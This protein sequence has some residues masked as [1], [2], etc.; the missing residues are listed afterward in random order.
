M[1]PCLRDFERFYETP[2]GHCVR[3]IVRLRCQAVFESWRGSPGPVLFCGYALPYADL[4]AG[5][6]IILMHQAQ[7]ACA[8]PDIRHNRVVLGNT[9]T[10]PLRAHQFQKAVLIH[11]LEFDHETTFGDQLWEVLA[12]E[13]EVLMI[14]PN[15]RSALVQWGHTPWGWGTSSPFSEF[16][17]LLTSVGFELEEYKNFFFVPPAH[18]PVVLS[19]ADFCEKWGPYLLGPF[20]GLWL[21]RARKRVC[22]PVTPGTHSFVWRPQTFQT[23]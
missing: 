14:V 22:A 23:I 7:G 10:M 17:N 20:G 4:W 13:A 16:K 19:S 21:V 6:S 15:H 2:L 3:R 9:Q 8:W 5:D 18:H 12:P 11:S 1:V